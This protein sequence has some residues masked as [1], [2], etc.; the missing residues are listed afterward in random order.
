MHGASVKIELLAKAAINVKDIEDISLQRRS[1]VFG[2]SHSEILDSATRQAL[3]AEVAASE[4]FELPGAHA[5]I[6]TATITLQHGQSGKAGAA[7]KVVTTELSILNDRL[8][9][10]SDGKRAAQA[11]PVLRSLLLTAR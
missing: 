10:S 2:L 5:A 1:P 9:L 11:G 4:V 7:K 3:A 8:V 6:V